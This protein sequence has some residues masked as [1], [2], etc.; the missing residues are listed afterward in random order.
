ML[1]GLYMK[2]FYV[3]MWFKC[4]FCQRLS[5]LLSSSMDQTRTA[6]VQEQARTFAKC[7][8]MKRNTGYCLFFQGISHVQQHWKY[9]CQCLLISFPLYHFVFLQSGR[10]LFI[11]H[12]S[13]EP[14]P[15]TTLLVPWT[16]P[17]HQKVH[18]SD[19]LFIQEN[20]V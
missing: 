9:W 13:S 18:A 6:S 3:F 14:R 2:H 15:R 8:E 19:E 11:P 1:E 10:R 4:F 16:Q 5:E 7:L 20:T 12:M 17:F